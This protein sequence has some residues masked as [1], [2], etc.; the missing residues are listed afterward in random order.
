MFLVLINNVSKMKIL[1][2]FILDKISFKMGLKVL[3]ICLKYFK[4]YLYVLN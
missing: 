3:Y 4:E 1:M 2:E